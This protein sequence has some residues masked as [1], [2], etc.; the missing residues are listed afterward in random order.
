[1]AEL[2]DGVSAAGQRQKQLTSMF[3]SHAFSKKRKAAD[4]GPELQ[5]SPKAG[6]VQ[7]SRE[8]TPEREGLDDVFA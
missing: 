7:G 8:D 1:M 3:S 4:D 2:T 6:R 5:P